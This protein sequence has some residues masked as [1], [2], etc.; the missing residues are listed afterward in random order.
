MTKDNKLKRWGGG[1]YTA[2]KSGITLELQKSN[3]NLIASLLIVFR[4]INKVTHIAQTSIES[5]CKKGVIC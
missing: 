1:G 4:D 2:R 3:F 5:Q